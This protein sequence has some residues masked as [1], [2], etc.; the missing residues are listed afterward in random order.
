MA[1]AARF[2]PSSTPCAAKSNNGAIS[3]RSIST[4]GLFASVSVPSSA[5]RRGFN[6]S[7]VDYCAESEQ[8]GRVRRSG[9]V[10]SDT[11]VGMR[12]AEIR[13]VR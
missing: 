6:A 12:D 4:Y 11:V 8:R 5:A 9:E 10:V 2:S 1:S 7:F 13:N 3:N